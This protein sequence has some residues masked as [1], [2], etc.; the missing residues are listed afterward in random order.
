[1][2]SIGKRLIDLK[3][4]KDRSAFLWGPRK[5][6]KSYWLKNN[7][8]KYPNLPFIDL[9]KTKE[10]SEYATRPGLL[11]ERYKDNKGLIIIDEI[12]KVPPLLD[13][14]HWLIENSKNHFILTGSS[15]RKLKRGKAN[16]LGGRAWRYHMTPLS[17]MEVEGF[18]LEEV[19][20]SGLLPP[21]YLSSHPQKD[22]E[23]YVHDYLKEEIAGE[24]LTQNLPAFHEFLRVAALTS[25]ELLSYANVASECGVSPK[26]VRTYFDILEDT[27]LG[28][29]VKPWNKSKER[30]LIQT[31]KFYLFD[32]G[33]KNYLAKSQPKIGSAEFGKSFEHYILMELKAYQAYKN[34]ELD[35]YFWRTAND[36]EVDFILGDKIAALEIKASERVS[37]KDLRHLSVLLEDGPVKHKIVICLEHQVRA[38]S[39]DIK[40][41]PWKHFL[42]MLWDGEIV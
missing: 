39:Q 8:G 22:L 13:E 41:W 4:P 31:E 23:A 19:M 21:H 26:I 34:P 9:L 5:S 36:Q 17:F 15:A 18:D 42:Q 37:S 24:A 2:K 38:L 11:S 20:S 10:Y 32:V 35:I 40:I 6:G 12:Q 27:Y 7:Y 29:R 1:M 25:S 16:L 14:V 30:R 33:V 3:L 28:F